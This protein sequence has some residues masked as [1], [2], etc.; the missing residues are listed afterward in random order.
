[1]RRLTHCSPAPQS[2]LWSNSKVDLGLFEPC[3]ILVKYLQCAVS[4][5]RKQTS[6]T[7]IPQ[8]AKQKKLI[9]KSAKPE[10]IYVLGSENTGVYNLSAQLDLIRPTWAKLKGLWRNEGYPWFSPPVSELSGEIWRLN[11]RRDLF[12]RLL[13][14]N[15]ETNSTINFKCNIQTRSKLDRKT[16]S[17][18]Q[19]QSAKK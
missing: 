4:P 2:N 16:T 8:F 13:I 9:P 10:E 15:I 1:M 12:L 11:Y 19:Q 6:S 18:N 5:S 7:L 14:S 3:E 17:F